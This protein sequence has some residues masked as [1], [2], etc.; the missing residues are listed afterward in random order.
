MQ[1]SWGSFSCVGPDLLTT[2]STDY[3]LNS[4]SGHSAGDQARFKGVDVR[5]GARATL[6]KWGT[7]AADRFHRF[8]ISF[9]NPKCLQE[10]KSS[11]RLITKSWKEEMGKGYKEESMDQR[12]IKFLKDMKEEIN[13]LSILAHRL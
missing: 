1:T 5:S 8:Y 4:C 12:K 9:Q 11:R 2:A 13:D 7:R 6:T 10:T 3:S